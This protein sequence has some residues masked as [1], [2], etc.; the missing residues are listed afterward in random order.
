M[1]RFFVR[2]TLLASI[3]T[4]LTCAATQPRLTVTQLTSNPN[5][6]AGSGA[7]YASIDAKA[8]HV[9]FTSNCDLVAGGNTDQNAELF[10]MNTDGTGL[11]QLTFTTG[12]LGVYNC[13]LSGSGDQIVFAADR[14]LISGQNSD[15]NAEIF[16][17]HSDGSG[18]I[19]LTHSTGG[20]PENFGGNS[21]PRLDPMGRK[22]TFSSDRDLVPGSNSDGN[23]ELFVVNVNGAGLRQLTNTVGGYGV[24]APSGLDST[25][26]KVVFDS[27]RDMVTG[28]NLDGNYD[29]FMMNTDGSG[30]VQ[31]TNTIGGTGC[32]GPVITPNA[33]TVTYWSDQ[34]FV[35]NNA[36][37][38][39]EVIRMNIDASGLIQLT[40]GTGGFGSAPWGIS[41]DGKTIS[42]ESDRDL[43]PGSN[44]GGNLEIYLIS[45]H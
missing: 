23:H 9:V 43:V 4:G 5:C 44:S 12:G 41:S 1:R 27:D 11:K 22:V 18:L 32:V 26:T 39:Y 30:L 19:Q 31:L 40:A 14:D 28:G 16:L 24:F 42:V 37:Q 36:D 8:L 20:D 38:D 25:D 10:Y 45:L 3:T 7:V 34:D 35:G 29:L 2:A 33:Q 21:H 6:N 17:I 13:A 15:L